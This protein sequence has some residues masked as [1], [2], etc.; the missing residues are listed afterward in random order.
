MYIPHPEN[1][2]EVSSARFAYECSKITN[3][4]HLRASWP[5]SY[6]PRR[7]AAG[8]W[9][10]AYPEHIPRR[11]AR[12]SG[13]AR[14]YKRRKA[15]FLAFLRDLERS[16]DAQ[17]RRVSPECFESYARTRWI[18]SGARA[19]KLRASRFPAGDARTPRGTYAACLRSERSFGSMENANSSAAHKRSRR[20]VSGPRKRKQ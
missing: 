9:V 7:S 11:R 1:L 3:Q 16:R 13:T 20:R 18:I 8:K 6:R 4:A 15:R 5:R 17:A 19:V 12:G 10:H 14:G 2:G